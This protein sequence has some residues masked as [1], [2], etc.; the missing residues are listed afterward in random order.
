MHKVRSIEMLEKIYD[1]PVDSHNVKI[2]GQ[3][4]I[5]IEA[6]VFL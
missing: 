5:L 1:G 2:G 4:H 6:R 3:A